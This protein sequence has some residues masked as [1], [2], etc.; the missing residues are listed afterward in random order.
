MC[1]V[2]WYLHVEHTILIVVSYS[3]RRGTC[4]ETPVLTKGADTLTLSVE[5]QKYTPRVFLVYEGTICEHLSRS[6]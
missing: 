5:L 2:Q 6:A 1:D 3:S 4:A